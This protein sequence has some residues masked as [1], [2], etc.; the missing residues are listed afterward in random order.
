MPNSQ[1]NIKLT[2]LSKAACTVSQETHLLE[3]SFKLA[4]RFGHEYMDEIPL[5]GEPG[6]FVFSKATEVAIPPSHKPEARAPSRAESDRTKAEP[7]KLETTNV[8]F[9]SRKSSK[10][11]E[12]SP[13]TPNFKEKRMR[14]KSKA[15]GVTAGSTPK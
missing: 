3:D 5:V 11:G 8:D 9:P 15:T 2:T 6:A 1:D 4:T 7:Q 14:R 12:N 10:G 13:I